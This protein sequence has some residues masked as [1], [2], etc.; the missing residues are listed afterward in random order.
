[1]FTFD[2]GFGPMSLYTPPH[3]LTDVT[4]VLPSECPYGTVVP[5]DPA[6]AAKNGI[7]NTGKYYLIPF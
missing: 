1:M 4:M 7:P 6:L 2:L 5:S 3:N